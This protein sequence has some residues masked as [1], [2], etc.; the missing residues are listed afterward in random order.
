MIEDVEYKFQL[1]LNKGDYYLGSAVIDFYLKAMP[2]QGE[3]F[4]SS[5]AM[6]ISELQINEKPITEKSAFLNQ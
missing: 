6:V 2:E 3:L 5:N 1:A 4:L